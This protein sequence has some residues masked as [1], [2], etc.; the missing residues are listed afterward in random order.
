MSMH[1]PNESKGFGR[2]WLPLL[3]L[4][5]GLVTG[6]MQA[7]VLADTAKPTAA[8]DTKQAEWSIERLMQALAHRKHH[9]AHYTEKKYIGLLDTPMISSGELRYTPPNHLEKRTTS[10]K[11][12]RMILDGNVLTF[13]QGDKTYTLNLDDHPAAVAYA[14]SIRGLLAGNLSVLRGA[15]QLRMTG[16]EQHW[17][18]MLHPTNVAV[19]QLIDSITV[20]GS[21]NQIQ[22]IEYDQ[23]DGDRT[24]MTIEPDQP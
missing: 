9:T 17:S 18:L 2:R 4:I 8:A 13:D 12:E 3:C 5:A 22:R 24:V 15:Y 20:T 19:S 23:T 7:P 6:S 10:P 21:G 16:D 1:R 14:D 11:Q